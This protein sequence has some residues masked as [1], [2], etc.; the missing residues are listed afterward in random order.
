MHR[1]SLLSVLLASSFVLSVGCPKAPEAAV[2]LPPNERVRNIDLPFSRRNGDALSAG[3]VLVLVAYDG[4][5][6]DGHD[7]VPLERGALRPPQATLVAIPAIV[8]AV[9]RGTTEVRLRMHAATKVSTLLAVVM[10]L[11]SRGVTRIGFDVRKDSLG[12][13]TGTIV[14]AQL[15]ARVASSEPHRFEPPYGRSWEQIPDVWDDAYVACSNSAGSFD[16]SPVTPNVAFGA[17][18]EVALF[19]RQNGV[20]LDMRRF[21]FGNDVPEREH[22][23]NQQNDRRAG[24][25]D[26][27][28]DREAVPPA[29]SA[30]FG[31]RW[32]SLSEDPESP[33]AK[34]MRAITAAG[35]LGVRISAVANDDAGAI[36]S[37]IGASFPEGIP[38]PAVMLDSQTR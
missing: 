9:P 29:T 38:A 34:V 33:I 11:R 12:E 26:R 21:G 22:F 18:A 19:R 30:S 13:H 23:M 6:I 15:D 10:S 7:V 27:D 28:R 4:V 17:D 35:P 8:D 5:A 3:A 2:T 36:V 31:F 1:R 24:V 14:P 32:E 25:R 20:I 16:C 37:L